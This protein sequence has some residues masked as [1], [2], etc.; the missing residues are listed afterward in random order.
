M[1]GPW[2]ASA[3]RALNA[4]QDP[5]GEYA[6]VSPTTTTS[7]MIAMGSPEFSSDD[8]A[9]DPLA[10][11]LP[12]GLADAA[13]PASDVT[14]VACAEIDGSDV[15]CG[16]DGPSDGRSDADS[17]SAVAGAAVSRG[18]GAATTT[19]LGDAAG[20]SLEAA[21]DDDSTAGDSPTALVSSE[22]WPD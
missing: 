22:N 18:D 15:P 21:G 5:S 19:T 9:G 6:A 20:A 8:G 16:W 11:A 7:L 12:D 17:D 1:S 10:S 2:L 4:N 14:G 13:P 3:G